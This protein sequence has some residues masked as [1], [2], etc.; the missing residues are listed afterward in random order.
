MSSYWPA[1]GVSVVAT[2]LLVWLAFAR[3][4]RREA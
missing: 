2:A 1:L 4:G 3:A